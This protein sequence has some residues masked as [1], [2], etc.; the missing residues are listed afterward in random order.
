MNPTRFNL[1][2]WH[3]RRFHFDVVEYTLTSLLN[4]VPCLSY[5]QKGKA[6]MTQLL[7][8]ACFSIAAKIEETDAPLILDLQVL[9][10][11]ELIV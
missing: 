5:L 6:W 10:T 11:S 8:V 9:I 2:L 3:F 4:F 1:L 7:S